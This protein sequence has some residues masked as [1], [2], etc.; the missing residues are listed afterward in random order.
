MW[1]QCDNGWELGMG[2]GGGGGFVVCCASIPACSGRHSCRHSR[3]P[4]RRNFKTV[5]LRHC[6]T[7]RQC[8]R[9]PCA[10]AALL[11]DCVCV[12]FLGVRLCIVEDP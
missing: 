11:A 10:A 6:V 7:A 1:C 4:N 12:R 3:A 2:G 5:L 8:D 9:R